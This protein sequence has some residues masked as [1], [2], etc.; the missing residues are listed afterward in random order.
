MAEGGPDAT[1][2]AYL[3]AGD[4]RIQRCRSCGTYV[5]QPRV[6]CPSC[7]HDGF[8][9]VTPSGRGVVHSTTVVRRKP[10]RGGDYNVCLVDLDEG[11]RLMSRVEGVAP[12]DVAI[13]MAVNARLTDQDGQTIVVFDPAQNASAGDGVTS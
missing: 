12:S 10:D 6:M 5:F 9:W 13:G 7:G 11:V 3:D 2:F 1:Y 4:W 8:D